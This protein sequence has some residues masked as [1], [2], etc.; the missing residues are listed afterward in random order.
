MGRV[1]VQ[2]KAGRLRSTGRTTTRRSST[3]RKSGDGGLL[4]GDDAELWSSDGATLLCDNVAP[5]D[6]EVATFSSGGD[7]VL[8]DGDVAVLLEDDIT[9]SAS[10][11]R[12]CDAP[13]NRTPK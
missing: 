5:L 1:G 12:R 9:A 13:H 6:S 3:R 7:A 4:F 8:L 11:W 10:G 2:V